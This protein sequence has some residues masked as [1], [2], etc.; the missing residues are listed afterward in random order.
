MTRFDLAA[1]IYDTAHITGDF[2]LRSGARSTEY[3]DKYL[4]EAKPELLRVIAEHLAPLIPAGTD[5]LSG[6]ELGGVPLATALSL[7]TGI[8]AAFVRKKAKEYGT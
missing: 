6:L 3:F 5:V 4:F 1:A 7:H 8:P 2:L